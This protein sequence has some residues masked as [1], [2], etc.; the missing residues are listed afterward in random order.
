MSR[1]R[2]PEI[3]TARARPPMVAS[4]QLRPSMVYALTIGGGS[5]AGVI[6]GERSFPEFEAVFGDPTTDLLLG[7]LGA[8]VAGLMYEIVDHIRGL[9]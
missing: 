3:W 5:V 6:V 1:C 4:M 8:I 9:M 7:A 2:Y